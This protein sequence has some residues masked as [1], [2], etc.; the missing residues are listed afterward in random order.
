[1]KRCL[2]V[3]HCSRRRSNHGSGAPPRHLGSNDAGTSHGGQSNSNRNCSLG[4]KFNC[5]LEVL[6][7][8]Q[9][10]REAKDVHHLPE[11][12]IA[13]RDGRKYRR[14]NVSMLQVASNAVH[15]GGEVLHFQPRQ[16]C[17]PDT[18]TVETIVIR[19]VKR[20]WLVSTMPAW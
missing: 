18:C 6:A 13:V 1:M 16:V 20:Y 15:H 9:R 14:K 7:N 10:E 11:L 17:L 12:A 5:Q 8:L 3:L 19:K 2:A 4:R